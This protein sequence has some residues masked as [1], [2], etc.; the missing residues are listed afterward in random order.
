MDDYISKPIDPRL[1]FEAVEQSRP[2]PAPQKV[3]VDRSSLLE[4]VGGDTALMREVVGLFL[5]DCPPRLAAIRRAVEQRDPDALRTEAHALKGA[6]GNLSATGLA[7]AARVLEQLAA[8]KRLDPVE[9]AWRALAAEAAQV[10]T[11]LRQISAD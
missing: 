10:L 6:A 5:E 3:A 4:R 1:L 11:T 8:A 9:G 7:E 2:A